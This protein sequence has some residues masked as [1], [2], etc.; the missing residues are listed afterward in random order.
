[1]ARTRGTPHQAAPS[2]TTDD[3]L[4]LFRCDEAATFDAFDDAM[5]ARFLVAAGAGCPP[6]ASPFADAGAPSP[7][8]GGR[9]FNGVDEYAVETAASSDEGFIQGLSWGI[10]LWVFIDVV[11]TACLIELGTAAEGSSADNTQLSFRTNAGGSLREFHEGPGTSQSNV[12][13][14]TTWAGLTT[15][16][17][18]LGLAS[19]PDREFIGQQ[20]LRFYVDGVCVHIA[21]NL[22]PP[23]GGANSKWTIGDIDGGLVIPFDGVIDDVVVCKWSPR[24][25]WFRRRYADGIRD[26]IVRGDEQGS[27][28]LVVVNQRV[29]TR[30]LVEVGPVDNASEF[31]D[32][33]LVNLTDVNLSNVNGEGIDLVREVDFGGSVDDGMQSARIAMLPRWQ[34]WNLS[35]FVPATGSLDDNPLEGLFNRRRRIKI[36]QAF[37]PAGMELEQAD[38][39]FRV[40]FD[41]IAMSPGVGRDASV[42][43]LDMMSALYMTFMEPHKVTGTNMPDSDQIYGSG[44]GTAIETDSQ[45]LIDRNDPARFEII[46]IDDNGGANTILIT[47]KQTSVEHGR[48]RTHPFTS[49]DQINIEG[50]GVTAYNGIKTVNAL[51]TNNALVRTVETTGGAEASSTIGTVTGPPWLSYFGGKPTIDVPVSPSWNR[52]MFNEPASKSVGQALEDWWDEIGWRCRMVWDNVREEHRL[53]AYEQRATFDSLTYTADNVYIP[54]QLAL[55]HEDQRTVGE[56]E[57]LDTATLDNAGEPTRQIVF[58]RAISRLR[59]DGRF[60]YRVHVG[61]TSLINTSTEA[62]RLNDMMLGDLQDATADGTMDVPADPAPEVADEITILN[63]SSTAAQMPLSFGS[64]VYAAIANVRHVASSSRSR[65][66][67]GLRK[68]GE[69]PLSF[70]IARARRATLRI[71]AQGIRRGRGLTPPST[72]AAPTCVSL[73][74]VGGTRLGLISWAMPVREQNRAWSETEVHCSSVS[75]AFTPSSSTLKAIVR[76]TNAIVAHGVGAGANVFTKLIHRDSLGNRSQPSANTTFVS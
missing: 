20:C 75:S 23:S 1:V 22:N 24:H 74:S 8:R 30:V 58:E 25:E 21:R 47:L 53:R 18:H 60:A 14:D 50:T 6:A 27:Q 48:G 40:M 38:P 17:H 7:T 35:P 64:Q 57:Y 39:H 11:K 66:R 49:G 13:T 61:S 54:E 32:L 36:E 52:F 68:F 15:G 56:V 44:G 67:L 69:S 10:G 19:E 5:S 55:H 12:I 71:P 70:S 2:G 72:P 3:Y 43:A 73:G 76:G 45:A 41:G 9:S 4:F 46:L 65:T 42:T 26:F 31:S 63:E 16:A 28:S 37:V 51:T 29:Y 59:Q 33:P 62:D 34:F